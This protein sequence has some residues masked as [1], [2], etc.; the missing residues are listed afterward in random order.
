MR[1][2]R[3][4]YYRKKSRRKKKNHSLSVNTAEFSLYTALSFD[5]FRYNSYFFLSSLLLVNNVVACTL[6]LFNITSRVKFNNISALNHGSNLMGVAVST[7]IL[8][9]IKVY[10]YFYRLNDYRMVDFLSHR[11]GLNM[12]LLFNLSANTLFTGFSATS[13]LKK[14]CN[15]NK[16]LLEH[17]DGGFASLK[18]LN[19]LYWAGT[20]G[21]LLKRSA[22]F[23]WGESLLKNILKPYCWVDLTDSGLYLVRNPAHNFNLLTL[24]YKKRSLY[25]GLQSPLGRCLMSLTNG[26]FLSGYYRHTTPRDIRKKRLSFLRSLK[27]KEKKAERKKTKVY[28]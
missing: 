2:K 28:K 23:C 8:D 12:N 13:L 19:R 9:T 22:V 27:H 15:L 7:E 16:V 1:W 25:I 14:T 26:L 21:A 18:F 10:T 20:A 4:R 24:H 17:A 11:A 6:G 3:R 5:K